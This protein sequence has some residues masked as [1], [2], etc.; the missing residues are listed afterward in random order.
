MDDYFQTNRDFRCDCCGLAVALDC[1]EP[2]LSGRVSMHC[3]VWPSNAAKARRVARG[4]IE[5]LV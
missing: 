1:R 3:N 5:G 4:R 2:V